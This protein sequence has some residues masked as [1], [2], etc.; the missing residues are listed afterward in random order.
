VNNRWGYAAA[1]GIFITIIVI[2]ISAINFAITRRISSEDN[3]R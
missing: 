1:I 2:I 3:D